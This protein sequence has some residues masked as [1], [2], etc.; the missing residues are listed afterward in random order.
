MTSAEGLEPARTL[1]ERL[2]FVSPGKEP[3]VP[4]SAGNISSLIG[5]L[6]S[7]AEKQSQ[8]YA[9]V[10]PQHSVH[11]SSPG[12]GNNQPE[13]QAPRE[14]KAPQEPWQV[15]TKPDTCKKI[16]MVEEDGWQIVDEYGE[17][18]DVPSASPSPPSECVFDPSAETIA[19]SDENPVFMKQDTIDHFQWRISNLPYPESVYDIAVDDRNQQIVVRTQNRKYY[20]RID[21]PELTDFGL[22]LQN[23]FLSWRY[24]R[25]TL[26]VSYAK[27]SKATDLQ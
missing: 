4:D 8:T 13:R 26:V 2:L 5:Q 22:H 21:V 18:T 27:P 25:N 3:R 16:Y 12:N 17:K 9:L 7:L 10:Q 20:K 23:E 14:P 24:Q 19:P 1:E 11:Q 15:C 6:A